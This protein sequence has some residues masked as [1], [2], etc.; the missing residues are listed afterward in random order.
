MEDNDFADACDID[1]VE[2]A[3]T[4]LEV[5]LLPLFPDG[6]DEELE[7]AWQELFGDGEVH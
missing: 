5:E 7:K 2:H 1:F 4:E 6:F 3:S